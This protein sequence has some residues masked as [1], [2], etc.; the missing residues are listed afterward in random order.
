MK[1]DQVDSTVIGI[2]THLPRKKASN[3]IHCN[4]LFSSV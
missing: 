1:D 4:V 2:R 3:A